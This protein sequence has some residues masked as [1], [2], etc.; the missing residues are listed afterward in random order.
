MDV[1]IQLTD[2]NQSS[3]VSSALS[4]AIQSN[5]QL[6]Q[7]ILAGSISFKNLSQPEVA[8]LRQVLDRNNYSSYSFTS[9][10]F[11][12]NAPNGDQERLLKFFFAIPYLNESLSTSIGQSALFFK[13]L[14]PMEY[15][16]I[17]MALMQA[18]INSM[19]LLE[20]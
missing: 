16:K 10:S 19:I 13:S 9:S 18:E 20:F 11:H 1:L 6:Q 8:T 3:A 12:L 14:Y 2:S 15:F 17:Y 5:P 7:Q 4:N